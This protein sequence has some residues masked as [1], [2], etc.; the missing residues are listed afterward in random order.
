MLRLLIK[1]LTTKLFQTVFCIVLPINL[2]LL[3]LKQNNMK[4]IILTVAAIMA[5][6]FA[7][8]QETS[9]GNGFSKGD[10]WAEGSFSFRSGDVEDSWAFN[11]KIGYMVNDKWGVGGKLDFSGAEQSNG[12]KSGTFGI[13]VFARNYFLSLGAQKSFQAYGEIG[14]GYASLATEPNG[15]EK[16]TDSAMSA[17]IDLGMNYFFTSHW[18]ATFKLANIL[19]Y[20][21]TNPENGDNASDLNVNVN[22]FNNIFAQPQFGLLYKW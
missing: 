7:N 19:S 5:F 18:A 16:T 6:G 10:M 1:M 17:N 9:S 13:G 22:L 12:N 21:S 11:P 8:A 15:G 14:L 2:V 4:K 20:N 3:I